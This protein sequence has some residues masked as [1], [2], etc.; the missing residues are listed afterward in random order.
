MRTFRRLKAL[1]LSRKLFRNW[2]PAGI[3][4]YLIGRGLVGGGITVRFRCGDGRVYVL[5]P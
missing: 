4:Y 1:L 3:R 2:L 5:S